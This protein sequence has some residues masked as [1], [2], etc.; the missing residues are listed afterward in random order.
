MRKL[1]NEKGFSAVILI[2][3]IIVICGIVFLGWYVYK[4]NDKTGKTL[5]AISQTDNDPKT[6]TTPTPATSPTPSAT[7]SSTK[8]EL[9]KLRDFCANAH[10]NTVVGTVQY[11]E[12][13]NGKY[14]YCVI[15]DANQESGGMMISF[16]QNGEWTKIFEGNGIMDQ[17]LCTQYKIPTAIYGDCP[18]YYN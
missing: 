1:I 14:G 13:S 6:S 8:N 15:G 3:L 2:L 10:A 12:N 11:I 18:G 9:D 4:S 5:D 7:T 16:Y 17:N